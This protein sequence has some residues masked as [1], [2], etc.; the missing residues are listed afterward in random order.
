[1][2]GLVAYRGVIIV[3]LVDPSLWTR[4]KGTLVCGGLILSGYPAKVNWLEMVRFGYFGLI[5][6]Q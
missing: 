2:V 1:M 3:G 6:F 4:S 5:A